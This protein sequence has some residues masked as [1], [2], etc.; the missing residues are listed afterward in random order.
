M[1]RALTAGLTGL[2][3]PWDV[4][5]MRWGRGA[6]ERTLKSAV[7]GSCP[8]NSGDMALVMHVSLVLPTDLTT[9]K[10]AASRAC[11]HGSTGCPQPCADAN[12]ES[13]R[14]RIVP[15]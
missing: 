8:V 10:H 15:P 1:T 12:R 6:V 3:T 9:A 2:D 5:M 14:H 7:I 11:A 13:P 4:Y